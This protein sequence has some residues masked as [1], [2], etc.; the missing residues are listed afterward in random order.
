MFFAIAADPVF[1]PDNM[2]ALGAFKDA[3]IVHF[4]MVQRLRADRVLDDRSIPT[5]AL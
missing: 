5:A 2:D 4:A 1:G 3:R